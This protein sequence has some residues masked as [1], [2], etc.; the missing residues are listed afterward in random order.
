VAAGVAAPLPALPAPVVLTWT[1]PELTEPAVP[2]FHPGE[3]KAA[4]TK[5]LTAAAGGRLPTAQQPGRSWP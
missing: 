4:A 5:A 1:P 3:A 2:T